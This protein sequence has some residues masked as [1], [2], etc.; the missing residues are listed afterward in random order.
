M[1]IWY[2]NHSYQLCPVQG[3]DK[4]SLKRGR[5]MQT[6]G[7]EESNQQ[8]ERVHLQTRPPSLILAMCQWHRCALS[9]YILLNMNTIIISRA[10][11]NNAS[12]LPCMYC[13]MC[14]TACIYVCAL[15]KTGS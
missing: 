4:K 14:M 2:I 8:Q 15:R 9:S 12:I 5:E 1:M 10:I 11:Q 13:T 6:E 7:Y 3:P